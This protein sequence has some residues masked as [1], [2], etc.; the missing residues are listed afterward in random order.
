MKS[1]PVFRDLGR[2][3]YLFVVAVIMIVLL[4]VAIWVNSSYASSDLAVV[5]LATQ[6]ISVCEVTFY[7]SFLGISRETIKGEIVYTGV[8]F[9]Q[10]GLEKALQ[11]ILHGNVEWR[12]NYPNDNP[13]ITKAKL[14]CSIKDGEFELIVK[15]R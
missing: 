7:G 6:Q 14:N 9:S 2:R 12:L 1:V 10:L 13:D 5:A 11:A 4:G 8:D 15:K 3:K